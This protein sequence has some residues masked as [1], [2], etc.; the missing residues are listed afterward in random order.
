M[1]WIAANQ[2]LFS[3]KCQRT[4]CNSFQYKEPI[5]KAFIA[6]IIYDFYYVAC[7]ESSNEASSRHLDETLMR[8]KLALDRSNSFARLQLF[9]KVS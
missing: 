9:H 5:P 2:K 4:L 6:A 3:L 1:C 7:T 8:D